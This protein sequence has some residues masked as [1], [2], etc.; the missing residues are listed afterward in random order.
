MPR[1]NHTQLIADRQTQQDA[2]AQEHTRLWQEVSRL[3]EAVKAQDSLRAEVER[4]GERMQDLG[5]AFDR[6]LTVDASPPPVEEPPD[7]R[8]LPPRPVDEDLAEELMF[9]PDTSRK[10]RMKCR[11]G[12]HEPI[13]A[14]RGKPRPQCYHCERFYRAKPRWRSRALVGAACL[15]LLVVG[16]FLTFA[17]FPRLASSRDAAYATPAPPDEVTAPAAPCG[18]ASKV[19]CGW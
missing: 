9:P 16:F 1:Q 18:A 10:Q 3:R 2:L 13:K 5:R 7:A 8:G 17:I 12:F 6:L 11:L 15:A 4:L 14:L 19:A